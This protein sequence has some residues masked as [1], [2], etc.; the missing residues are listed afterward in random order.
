MNWKHWLYIIYIVLGALV[1]SGVISCMTSCSVS[2]TMD[3]QGCTRVVTSDTT[4]VKH[5]GLYILKH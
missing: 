1:S 5:T 2:H 4:F 3:A